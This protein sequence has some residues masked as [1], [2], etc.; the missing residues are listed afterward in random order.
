M[1]RIC[2]LVAAGLLISLNLRPESVVIG[3]V[4]TGFVDAIISPES[5]DGS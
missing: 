3:G 4:F 5:C 2:E 1:T